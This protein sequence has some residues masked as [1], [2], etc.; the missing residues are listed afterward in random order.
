MDEEKMEETGERG[1]K[2]MKVK[3][4]PK[5]HST[6]KLEE[7]ECPEIWFE[8]LDTSRDYWSVRNRVVWFQNLLDFSERKRTNLFSILLDCSIP[9]QLFLR[10]FVFDHP[11]L[12]LS[13]L[14]CHRRGLRT[15]ITHTFTCRWPSRSVRWHSVSMSPSMV[16]LP[17]TYEIWTNI[18]C[19]HH[20]L[21]VYAWWL[22]TCTLNAMHIKPS[23]GCLTCE[24]SFPP[25]GGPVSN[26]HCSPLTLFWWR[27]QL[28]VFL[29]F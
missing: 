11:R 28:F 18:Y 10:T 1:G 22:N 21:Q 20:R 3:T 14:I 2:K 19:T 16:C 27:R 9:E 24:H 4:D 15:R 23:A 12:I 25:P 13:N 29:R 6:P 17:A 26:L 5:T 7:R 8:F